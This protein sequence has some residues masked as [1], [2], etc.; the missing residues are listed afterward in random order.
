MSLLVAVDFSDV[1]DA[2]MEIVGRLARPNRAIYLLHVAEPDPSFI[3][4]EAGPDEVRHEV[5]VEF[6]R[7]HDQLQALAGRLRE[8]GHRVTALMVQ[9]PTV[10]TILEQADRVEAEVIVVGSHGRGKLFDVM[11]GSVSAGVIR[12]AKVPVLVVPSR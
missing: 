7:E 12:K 5:A 4:Y 9:G 1:S 11:V 10:A 8:A 2:Q 3:G 6:K